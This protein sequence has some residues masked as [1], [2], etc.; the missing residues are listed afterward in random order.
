VIGQVI[1]RDA[2]H[3]HIK[4]VT[5]LLQPRDQA[6]KLDTV[7]CQLA[8]PVRV[9]PNLTFM[10]TADGHPE[11]LTGLLAQCS[12][13]RHGGGAKI[14]MGVVAVVDVF[15]ALGHGMDGRK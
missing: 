3:E 1:A 13:L 8:A 9:R 6:L 10:H 15:R 2:M 11:Q 7:K 12:G 14:N 5:V 4:P